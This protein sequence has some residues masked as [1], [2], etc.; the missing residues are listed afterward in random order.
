MNDCKGTRQE[1]VLII[2]D[3]ACYTRV[4]RAII[5]GRFTYQKGFWLSVSIVLLNV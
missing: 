3:N 2:A 1:V 4:T 5:H